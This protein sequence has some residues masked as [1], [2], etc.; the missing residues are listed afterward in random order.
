VGPS[1]YLIWFLEGLAD[2]IAIQ[3]V[4]GQSG[5]ERS[6]TGARVRLDATGLSGDAYQIEG[7]NGYRFLSEVLAAMGTRT[8]A[9]LCHTWLERPRTGSEL[10]AILRLGTPVPAAA[11]VEQA[12]SRWT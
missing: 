7:G 12:I 9:D 5:Y 3:T 2:V 8:F 11:A 10:I 4:G 6:A 1:P